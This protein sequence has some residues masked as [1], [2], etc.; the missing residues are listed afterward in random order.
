LILLWAWQVF[1]TWG[2]WGNLTV[3]SGHEMYVPAV[4][5][6]G[7]TLYRDVWFI[8]GPASPYFNSYLFRLFG[9]HLNVLYWAGSL[10]AL[11][12][13]VFLY[14]TGMR[15]SARAAGWAAGAVQIAEAFHYSLFCFPLPYSFAAVYGCLVGCMFLWT[16]IIASQSTTRRWL[17]AAATLAATAFILK[18]E[19]G[20]AAYATLGVLIAVRSLQSRGSTLAADVAGLLPGLAICALVILW[21]VSLGGVDF[22]TQENIVAWPTSYFMQ[23]FGKMWLEQNGFT[24]DAQSIRDAAFRGLLP[25]GI[26]LA[27]Y[28]VRNWNRKHEFRWILAATVTASLLPWYLQVRSL[29]A[30][31]LIGALIF[32]RDMV[33]YVAL[34]AGIAWWCFLRRPASERDPSVP[35]LLSFSSLL[36]FRILMRMRADGYPIYYNGPVILAYFL[37]VKRALSKLTPSP[38]GHREDVLVVVTALLIVWAAGHFQPTP[39]LVPLTNPRGTVRVSS[40]LKRNYLAAI[41][42]MK[43]KAAAGESVLSVPEDTSLYF[44]AETHSPTRVYSFVPGVPAPGAMI[45]KTIEEIEQRQVRYLLWSNRSF[46][47]YGLP[48]FGTDFDQELGDYFRSHYRRVASLTPSGTWRADVW[49]RTAAFR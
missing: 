5:A 38:K 30:L 3:D 41:T 26:L 14:L 40:D 35:I 22:I 46:P 19:F 10:S 33:L 11:G 12:A 2:A 13:A 44:L 47:E 29:N 4:L 37:L 15:L 21:M 27:G 18:Q 49:E 6:E 17:L 8:N 1:V 9:I 34:A 23:H 31:S 24:L 42:F 16:A 43:E 28:C 32:P 45:T 48:I 20:I 7:K 39:E 25:A 36:A